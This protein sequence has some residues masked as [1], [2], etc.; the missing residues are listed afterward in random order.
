MFEHRV[1]VTAQI[2]RVDISRSFGAV[3]L[4]LFLA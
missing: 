2:I 1:V 3:L 4:G